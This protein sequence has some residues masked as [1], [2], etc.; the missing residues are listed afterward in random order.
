MEN[1]DQLASSSLVSLAAAPASR[2]CSPPLPVIDSCQPSALESFTRTKVDIAALAALPS[3]PPTAARPLPDPS[4]PVLVSASSNSTIF[5]VSVS[6]C[7][8]FSQIFFFFFF[9]LSLRRS[10]RPTNRC[11]LPLFSLNPF[12]HSAV[13]TCTYVRTYVCVCTRL[14]VARFA[15]IRLPFLPQPS[16]V[17][18]IS[19]CLVRRLF[20]F[21][22]AVFARA[23]KIDIFCNRSAC[24]IVPK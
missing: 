1:R 19:R 13:R 12:C 17:L 14:R 24:S 18:Q 4:R 20:V 21:F 10:S 9:F 2:L 5:F 6:L 11:S 16:L 22:Y 7:L 3:S 8:F 23:R 15:S